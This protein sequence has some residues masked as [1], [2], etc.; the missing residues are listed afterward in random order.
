MAAVLVVDDDA[1][2]AT[3]VAAVV[4]LL[5]HEVATVHSGSAAL[6]F[7]RSRPVDLVVLDVCMPGMSGLDV[8]RSLRADG[9]VPGLPVIMFSA[10]DDAR[11]DAMRLGATA[12]AI[13]GDS[14]GLVDLIMQHAPS[15]LPGA[16]P[17]GVPHAAYPLRPL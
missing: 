11:E 6:E 12:F 16:P 3:A 17:K 8:L 5:S 15:G 9:T 7:I 10:F 13:K 1:V 14:D 4:K 2:V